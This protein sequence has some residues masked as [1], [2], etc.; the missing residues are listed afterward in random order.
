MELSWES[1]FY[2]PT[3]SWFLGPV[4]VLELAHATSD[5]IWGQTNWSSV[6]NFLTRLKYRAKG[7]HDTGRQRMPSVS[8]KLMLYSNSPDPAEERTW[9][10]LPGACT[11]SWTTSLCLSSWYIC[12]IRIIIVPPHRFAVNEI[13]HVMCLA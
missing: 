8:S 4:V 11:A 7:L 10:R 1:Y 3:W 12:K 13:M 5:W 6:R 9:I 2:P